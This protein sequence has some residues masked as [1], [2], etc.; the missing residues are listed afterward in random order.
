[1]NGNHSSSES[2]KA[3]DHMFFG[4]FD[5]DDDDFNDKEPIEWIVLEVKDGKAFAISK[6][7]LVCKSYDTPDDTVFIGSCTSGKEYASNQDYLRAVLHRVSNWETCSL[8]KWLNE[9][10]L[11]TAFSETER[12]M[13]VTVTIPYEETPLDWSHKRVIPYND[14]QNK[15]FL[16]SISEVEKYFPTSSAKQC[17]PTD[18]AFI[19]GAFASDECDGCCRWWLRTPGTHQ[20]FQPAVNEYGDVWVVG[21]PHIWADVAVRPA[22]WLDLNSFKT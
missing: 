22:L 6:Y 2:L 8:R 15:I 17:N 5:Q 18:Y 14:T 1:M 19:H 20:E 9:D 21:A 13:I 4:K 3:G 12:K 7:A 10:F 11:N 16:L